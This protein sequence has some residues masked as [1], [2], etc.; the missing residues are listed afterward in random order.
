MRQQIPPLPGLHAF[1]AAARLG[2]FAAAADELHLSPAA[3][4]QRIRSLENW[5]GVALFERRARSVELTEMGV[6]YVST[7]RDLFDELSLTTAGLF[8]STSRRRLT[9]RVQVS[10]AT[11]WLMPRLQDFCESVPHVDL[12]VVCSIWADALPPDEVDLEIRQGNGSWAGFTAELL[13]EDKAALV[14]SP[15]HLER[16]GPVLSADDLVARPR[17]HVLGYDDM[18][19]RLFRDLP[20]DDERAEHTGGVITVDTSIA[21]TEFAAAGLHCALVPERFARAAVR[22][23]RLVLAH[24]RLAPMRQAHYLLRSEDTPQLSPEARAFTQ[25]LIRKDIEDGPLGPA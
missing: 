1:E 8:G 4:S 18:W 11:T 2:S 16:Y 20:A 9:V 24:H 6:A 10:Y 13:H 17:V 21:A 12:R 15:R 5:L 23:G 25:W 7:V 19:P 3:V 22:G 14:C